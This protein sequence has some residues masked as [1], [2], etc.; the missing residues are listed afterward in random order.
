[1]GINL[2]KYLNLKG[3]LSVSYG[4]YPLKF[5]RSIY[6]RRFS[7]ELLSFKMVLDSFEGMLA[8][9]HFKF[10]II[11]II[12]CA[13]FFAIDSSTLNVASMAL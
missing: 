13:P 10:L 7:K 6:E 9:R 8:E 12:I 11:Y 4:S 1:M 5:S 3:E 2:P